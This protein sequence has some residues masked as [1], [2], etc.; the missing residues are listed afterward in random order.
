MTI[1]FVI[2]TWNRYRFLELCLEALISSLAE[3]TNCEILVMNN[4]STDAT[5]Q[6]LDRY[7]DN[8]LL[9]VIHRKR[10]YGLNAYK[11]LLD[12]VD[13]DYIV[14]VDDDV[15]QFPPGLDRIFLDAMQAL[16]QYGYLALDVV[17]DD[18][19]NGAKPGPEHYSAET[20]NGHT[21]L[22]GPTGGW[23]TCF[24][25]ADFRKIRLGLKFANLNMK[26]SEDTF[27]SVTLEK[28]LGLKSG[29]LPGSVCLHACG[30]Y[31]AKQYGH[32]DREI[33]KYANSG[34]TTF[35]DAYREY[36]DK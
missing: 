25:R 27:L 14:V 6:V 31:Y 23:C 8:P 32:L 17:Q 1:G 15:I 10:N 22:R 7:R 9:R 36:R 19:T 12:A 33:E 4:G 29:I 30:P 2:L 35:V 11:Q 13:T 24:R 28:K 18:F 26:R 3:P 5:R 34:L 16:P 20:I 21:V